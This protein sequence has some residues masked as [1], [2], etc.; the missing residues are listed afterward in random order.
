MMLFPLAVALGVGL[1]SNPHPRVSGISATPSV[2]NTNATVTALQVAGTNTTLNTQTYLGVLGFKAQADTRAGYHRSSSLVGKASFNLKADFQDALNLYSGKSGLTLRLNYYEVGEIHLTAGV[3]VTTGGSTSGSGPLASQQAGAPGPFKV[4]L[5][6][7][8][9]FAPSMLFGYGTA[10][11][12]GGYGSKF[13][14]NVRSSSPAITDKEDKGPE[15]R[16]GIKTRNVPL[17]RIGTSQDFSGTFTLQPAEQ[18]SAKANVTLGTPE[19][20]VVSSLSTALVG[21]RFQNYVLPAAPQQFVANISTTGYTGSISPL[22]QIADPVSLSVLETWDMAAQDEVDF[23]ICSDLPTGTYNVYFSAPGFL[24]RVVNSVVF[25][26]T[27]FPMSVDLIRGD[28]NGDNKI[29][30]TDVNAIQA[31]LGMSWEH[32][33]WL[34]PN[35]NGIFA[36]ICDLNGDD[37]VSSADVSLAN[38]RVGLVGD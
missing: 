28:V 3:S 5:V 9:V 35:V 27:E 30:A 2:K 36:A 21:L 29:D 18:L 25:N 19:P 37:V 24:R 17:T 1:I 32:E 31:R 16:G 10:T 15:Q 26:D 8:A 34:T 14:F 12:S 33:D 6:G 13:T 4:P 22:V 11:G 23:L 38:S 20:Q 7:S